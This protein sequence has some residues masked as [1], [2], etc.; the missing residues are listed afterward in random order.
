[1]LLLMAF[2]PYCVWAQQKEISGTIKDSAGVPIP[3][4]T[5]QIQNGKSLGVTDDQ[6]F[7]RLSVQEGTTIIFSS[8]SFQNE[9]L[10]VGAQNSYNITMQSKKGDLN[11]VVVVGY[12]AQKKV[13]MTGAVSTI[14]AKQIANR[15][16]TNISS[17]LGG[18]A[19]GVSVA[20]TSGRPGSDGATIR[21]R[22]IGTLNN[23]GALIVIDGIIGTMDA[24][25]PNDVASI[26]IL[27]DAAAASIYG[28]QA[29]N[30]VILITT[31]KGTVGKP[32]FT[33]TGIFSQA[34]PNSTPK[35]VTDYARYMQLFNEG[36]TNIGQ[37]A[38]YPQSDIDTWNAAKSDP[39]QVNAYGYPNYVVYPNTDWGSE[40]FERNL[41]QNHNF[42]VLGGSENISYNLSARYMG[43]PGIVKNAGQNR[44][45]MRANVEAKV[46]NFLTLGTQ[47]FASTETFGKSAIDNLFNFLRQTNPGIYPM[48]D[49]I[50]G[51]P[52]STV[53][54]PGLN[55]LLVYLY[56]SGGSNQVTR[57]NSTLY[58]TIHFLKNLSLTSRFNYQLRQQETTDFSNPISRYSFNTNTI[59]VQAAP[60]VSLSTSQGFNKDY[61]YTFDNVLRYN[62]SWMKH[63]LSAMVGYNEYYYNYYTFSATKTGLI[64]ASITNIGTATTMTSIGGN[65]YDRSM[66]SF[67][68]RINYNYDEKYLFEAN[69]RRDA[70]SRFGTNN[71]WGTFPSFSAGW[72][73]SEESFFQNL[74]NTFQDV[75]LRGSWGKLGNERMVDANGNETYY[76]WQAN[77]SGY[78]YT[79]GGTQV[80][81]LAS[82]KIA[83]PDLK[84][85]STTQTDI[86]L[87]FSTFQRRLSV[88]L[89]VYNKTT[90]GILST[91]PLPLTAGNISAP[92]VNGPQVKNKGIEITLNWRGNFGEVNYTVGGNFAYNYNRVSKYKGKLV[93]GWS[94][95]NGT[96]VYN[97]NIGSVASSASSNTPIVE[98]HL[99]NEYYLRQIYKGNGSYK[100]ADGSVNKNGGPKDGMIRTA[101]DYQW[102][103]DMKTAGYSFS[104]VNNVGAS[105]L[106]YGDFIFADLNNDGIYGNTYDREFTG[107]SNVPK[108]VFGF[109][110]NFNW[111]GF[112]FSMI[113]QGAAGM[114]YYWNAE[115]YDNSIVRLTNQVASRIADDHYY[116]NLSDASDPRNNLNGHFPRLKLGG[117][118]INNTAS[119]FWLYKADYLKLKNAQIGYTLPSEWM[120]K[121]HVSNC[122]IFFSG[123]NLITITP[124]KGIDPELGANIGYPTMR[125]FAL[126][127]NLGL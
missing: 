93:E 35:F 97:S 111:K 69:F 92:T 47:T 98:D 84:W 76:D 26:S 1:M 52:T 40:I 64:D 16:V 105:Q 77:Y 61:A 121:L 29:A 67:F 58:A 39:N 108:Y 4:V 103:Q 75:K 14:G 60:A 117:D 45:E 100:N 46:S 24:V 23:A 15:P 6:G 51:A 87:E 89:D 80:V 95:V 33:Y 86:G 83:N 22:G 107:T 21:I 88:E 73:I 101:E 78:N 79:F 66:R 11:E 34:R 56:G 91:I 37:S 59:L 119:N 74:K 36:A 2:I 118:A 13:N 102:V 90:S 9:T 125:Q 5:I 112:D 8:V 81:G 25:N 10:K 7:F 110:A 85:E 126:G 63:N 41:I 113:W 50:F 20:Q 65:K 94:D 72:R 38:P 54:S 109:N 104:P 32:K 48:Y 99:I 42:Q 27:K 30:G 96:Q 114:Q 28:A 53:E 17:A 123:E 116:N 115:G 18:M 120:T 71:K 44:Y 68:G 19:T 82:S 127:I 106:Y 124:W 62:N 12:G 31:K 57:L 55:N 43:N 3:D 70:S 49:G 122:R